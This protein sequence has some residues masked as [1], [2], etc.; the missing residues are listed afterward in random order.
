[1]CR[2][3]LYSPA[4]VSAFFC[5]QWVMGY[6]SRQAMHPSLRF[7]FLETASRSCVVL[8]ASR[9]SKKYQTLHLELFARTGT[10]QVYYIRPQPAS[11]S[12]LVLHQGTERC[13]LEIVRHMHPAGM[14]IVARL[15]VM[16]YG[17]MGDVLFHLARWGRVHGG[18]PLV[19]LFEERVYR[20]LLGCSLVWRSGE[21]GRGC[22][23]EF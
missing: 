6:H 7:E 22:V 19:D 16:N 17:I 20:G 5:A 3:V 15:V 18:S 1:M 2:G 8:T 12:V 13:A 9:L 21:R 23:D 14:L 4:T 10:Y 11:Y